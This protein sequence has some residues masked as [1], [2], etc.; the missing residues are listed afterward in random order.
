MAA[1]EAAAVELMISPPDGKT[2]SRD[3]WRA[4]RINATKA[5]SAYP[6]FLAAPDVSVGIPQRATKRRKVELSR[7]RRDSAS[8][9]SSQLRMPAKVDRMG[10][11]ARIKATQESRQAVTRID[12]FAQDR[13]QANLLKQVRGSLPAMSSDL[14]CYK[15][16]AICGRNGRFR[17]RNSSSWSGVR[18]PR[19]G[20]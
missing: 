14:N 8:A 9:S 7:D 18:S 1:L 3:L 19:Y 12:R 13:T 4:D 20:H 16:S 15:R 5:P 2:A 17:P 6:L 10:R 11:S